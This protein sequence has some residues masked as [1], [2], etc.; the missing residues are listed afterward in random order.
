MKSEVKD[1]AAGLEISAPSESGLAN[2]VTPVDAA[3]P[4]SR[5]FVIAFTSE[6]QFL[7]SY[8]TDGVWRDAKSSETIPGVIAWKH[9]GG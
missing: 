9:I 2:G 7:G 1:S 5:E 3:V 6:F 8:G 4:G